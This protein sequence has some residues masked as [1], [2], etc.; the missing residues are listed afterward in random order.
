MDCTAAVTPP[1][2]ASG[3][4]RVNVHGG[5]G[6]PLGAAPAT[7]EPANAAANA[8]ATTADLR[9]GRRLKVVGVALGVSRPHGLTGGG[10][11]GENVAVVE[12]R[13]ALRLAGSGLRIGEAPSHHRPLLPIADVGIATVST[14]NVCLPLPARLRQ[15]PA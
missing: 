6:G 5:G 13:I 15:E 14:S 12:H 3:A 4:D 8:I 10:D 2:P 9:T 7:P 1:L 11:P